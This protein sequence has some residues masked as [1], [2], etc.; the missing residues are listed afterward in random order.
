MVDHYVVPATKSPKGASTRVGVSKSPMAGAE[1]EMCPPMLL[2]NRTSKSVYVVVAIAAYFVL[3]EWS[4]RSYVDHAPP[5]KVAIH[6]NRPFE[7]FG[8][9][10]VVSDQLKS[11]AS[12]EPLA[13]SV[14]DKQRSPLL[15]Y[16]NDKLLG[17]AHSTHFSI[18]ELGRGRYSH[19]QRLGLVFSSSDRSNPNRNG[20]SYWA[21][22]PR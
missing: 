21:V 22:I 12:I 11:I 1:P 17:P 4:K 9:V 14:D 3:A 8:E 15:L 2:W 6:L 13:D 5:G 18:A 19:W 20:R 7:T 10:G 16:E